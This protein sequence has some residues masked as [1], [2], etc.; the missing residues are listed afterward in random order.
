MNKLILA[1]FRWSLA[2]FAVGVALLA[3]ASIASAQI[4]VTNDPPVYG[5]YNGVFL[6]GGDGLRKPMVERDTVLLAD[7][8]WTLYAWV[9]PQESLTLPT[10]L[11]G[12]GLIDEEYP[13][14]LAYAGG[15][16]VLWMGIDNSSRRSRATCAGQAF[17]S[18]LRRLTAQAST[19]SPMAKRLATAS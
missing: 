18:S 8:P 13:R 4:P 6:A 19:S 17:T 12:V 11:A 7:S 16:L 2:S 14:Y 10:L 3:A 9:Q 1:A 5:P 15:K